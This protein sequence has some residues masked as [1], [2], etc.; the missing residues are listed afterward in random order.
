MVFTSTLEENETLRS[1]PK[2]ERLLYDSGVHVG[3]PPISQIF[4]LNCNM[5]NVQLVRCDRYIGNPCL[6]IDLNN[7][8]VSIL[9][10]VRLDVDRR[11]GYA[12][13]SSV[14]I[15]MGKTLGDADNVKF[16]SEVLVRL[17]I[18]YDVEISH[19]GWNRSW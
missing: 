16:A 11:A 3:Q 13:N 5:S 12:W 1:M 2:T 17:E 8:C 6:L 4:I 9:C 19:S 10:L 14:L 18:L 7:Y 15:S